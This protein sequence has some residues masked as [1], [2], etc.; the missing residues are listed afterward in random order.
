M[1]RPADALALVAMYGICTSSSSRA[2]D[3]STLHI[4]PSSS[5]RPSE[6]RSGGP[7]HSRT[8]PFPPSVIPVYM[9]I[10]LAIIHPGQRPIRLGVLYPADRGRAEKGSGLAG[11]RPPPWCLRL[12]E[13]RGKR[14][15]RAWRPAEVA[16]TFVDGT[17][18]PKPP[19]LFV[20]QP[21]KIH[22]RMQILLAGYGSQCQVTRVSEEGFGVRTPFKHTLS[23]CFI[24]VVRARLHSRGCRTKKKGGGVFA[25]Q[26][27]LLLPLLPAA[28]NPAL[29]LLPGRRE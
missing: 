18:S 28:R 20:R 11:L 29:L 27:F 6:P 4:L 19:G 1:C 2:V 13:T 10:G 25:N 8:H 9:N 23:L 22:K 21:P 26:R 5:F 3:N 12:P 7:R 16:K 14:I 17:P 15:H 24:S